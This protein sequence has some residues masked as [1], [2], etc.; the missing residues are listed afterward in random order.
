MDADPSRGT[1]RTTAQAVGDDLARIHLES[2]GT[3][4]ESTKTIIS[5]DAVVVF[6]DGLELMANEEFMIREGEED[7][8]INLRGKYQRAIEP[9][10]RAA[11]ERATGRKV[12]SFASIV[13]LDPTYAVEIFRLG[14]E[15]D[16]PEVPERE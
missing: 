2:Y 15:S 4:S 3:G 11:V 12:V 8:V 10:F 16:S 14:P 1:P 9:T 7:A 6:M 5:D 13:R